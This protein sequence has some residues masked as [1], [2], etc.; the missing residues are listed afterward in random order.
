MGMK[1]SK[2]LALCNLTKHQYYYQPKGGKGGAKPSTQT[3]KLSDN[4]GTKQLVSNQVVVD[5]IIAIKQ[6]PDTDYGYKAT[7]AALQLLGYIIN[8]KKVYR[9]MKAYQLLHEKRPKAKRNY[10]KYRSVNPTAPLQVLEMDIKF[11]WVMEQQRFAFILTVIDCFTRFI[12]GWQVAYSIKQNGVKQLWQHIITEY[13]QPNDLLNKQITVELRNDNDS[14]FAATMIQQ[15]FQQNHINQVFTHP[16]TPQENGHIES[17]H[18]ILGRSLA[19][20][21]FNIINQLEAHLKQFYHIY[22]YVRLHGSIDHLSPALFWK[23][24]NEDMIERIEKPNHKIRFR[25]KIP[26]YHLYGNSIENPPQQTV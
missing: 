9:L 14:R 23:L 18:A 21:D 15:Y 11:Q 24:W 20:R 17:F 12:L 10:V 6:H 25:L 7:T 19:P 13:L 8:H 5:E 3:L 1:V 2:A 4:R 26:H 22:N 16:Y